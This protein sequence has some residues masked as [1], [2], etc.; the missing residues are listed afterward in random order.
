MPEVFAVLGEAKL[1]Q[2]GA[3]LNE[4]YPYPCEQCGACCRHVDLID[5][6]KSFDR[7]DGVCK[8]LM[9]NNLCEIYSER[10]PLCNGEYVYR[11]F[12]ADMTIEDFHEMISKLCRKLRKVET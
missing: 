12:F 5:A 10:P 4:Y 6:M 1:F 7:G 11:N 3:T 9:A 2:G 8:H